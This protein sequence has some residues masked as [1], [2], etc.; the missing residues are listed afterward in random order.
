MKLGLRQGTLPPII[1]QPKGWS[2]DIEGVCHHSPNSILVLPEVS[3]QAAIVTAVTACTPTPRPHRVG[4]L[5]AD[6][7]STLR[8]SYTFESGTGVVVHVPLCGSVQAGPQ[9]N[10]LCNSNMSLT[11]C[12]AYRVLHAVQVTDGQQVLSVS[13]GVEMLTKITAAGCSVT[14]LIAGFCAAPGSDPL[15]ATAAALAVF[16]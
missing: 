15:L 14:A 9:G 8:Q 3:V 5:S 12:Q 16:G 7:L 2:V 1:Q 6:F 4:H 11:G 13:N 10:C